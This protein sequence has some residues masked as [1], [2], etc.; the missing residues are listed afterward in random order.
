MRNSCLLL[1]IFF[2]F[3]FVF[4]QET[5]NISA[6]INLFQND[7]FVRIDA[8]VEN[9][10]HIYK[11]E[12]NYQLLSLKRNTNSIIYD[13][14]DRF[15]EFNLLPNEKKSITSL[16]LNIEPNQE[17]KVYL[18]ITYNKQ[19]IA[20][21]SVKINEIINILKTTSIQED[22]IEIKGLVIENA[23]TTIGKDF[24][25]IFYQKYN[26]SGAKYSFTININEKPFIGGRGSLISVEIGDVKIFE[27]Q[28]RPDEELLNDAANYTLKLIENYNKNRSTFEKI[29]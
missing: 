4:T 2:Q 25:D 28:A 24:Y 5:E 8:V 9:S 7:V 12:L 18:F 15:G 10:D 22:E 11:N 1:V 16:K 21:D 17:L 14:E 6:K 3:H 19:L 13:R 27:F 26:R 23:R 20:Q 29:Y